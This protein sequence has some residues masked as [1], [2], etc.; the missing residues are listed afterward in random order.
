MRYRCGYEPQPHAW[1]ARLLWGP[2][3]GAA[4]LHIIA[5]IIEL[6]LGDRLPRWWPVGLQVVIG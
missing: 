1:V 3:D 6:N 5:V 2:Q 4:Y